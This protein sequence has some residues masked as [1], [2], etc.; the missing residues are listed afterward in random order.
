[1]GMAG[2]RGERRVNDW[3]THGTAAWGGHGLL[4]PFDAAPGRNKQWVLGR[5]AVAV[6]GSSPACP[7]L[8]PHLTRPG[9]VTL[10]VSHHTNASTQHGRGGEAWD[11]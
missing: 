9:Q 5:Q 1:M 2:R 3:G 6:L 8:G 11:R 10:T 4:V 7:L